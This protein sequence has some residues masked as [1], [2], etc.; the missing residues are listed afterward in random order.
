MRFTTDSTRPIEAESRN[1]AAEIAA[2]RLARRYYGHRKARVGALRCD[3]WNQA[4]TVWHYEAYIGR[5]TGLRETSG[6]N[7]RFTVY[8]PDPT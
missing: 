3:S 4:N 5:K 8:A 6:H 7:V 2:L 1:E